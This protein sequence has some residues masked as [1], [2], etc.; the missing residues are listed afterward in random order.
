[1]RSELRR[2]IFAFAARTS[3][4]LVGFFGADALGRSTPFE[5]GIAGSKGAG[6]VELRSTGCMLIGPACRG[7]RRCIIDNALP[8]DLFDVVEHAS[9]RRPLP[10]FSRRRPV[11][12]IEKSSTIFRE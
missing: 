8:P 4:V 6:I 7:L 12:P 10:A 3:S 9:Q 5:P 1:L 2:V 11:P